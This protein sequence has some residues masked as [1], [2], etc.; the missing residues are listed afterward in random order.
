MSTLAAATGGA[1]VITTIARCLRLAF[2]SDIRAIRT[3]PGTSAPMSRLATRLTIAWLH[4]VQPIARVYGRLRGA[5]MS[6]EFQL[7]GEHRSA[8]APWHQVVL[9]LIAA[10]P[11]ALRFWSESWLSREALLTR[12]VERLRSTRV[13][14]ALDID[15][16]WHRSR[17][18]GLQLGQWGQLDVQ[19]LVEEHERGRVLVRIA[20][21]LRVR[22]FFGAVVACTGAL[23][24]SLAN[25]PTGGWVLAIPILVVAVLIVRAIWHA[26][27]T[28][29]L[30]D[31]VMTR[32]LADA[33]AMALDGQS[34]TPVTEIGRATGHAS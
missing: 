22:P 24:L 26:T 2:A 5:L 28:M 4:L 15:D 3:M 10:R 1:A 21:R 30:A 9:W 6:P 13:A 19:L 7:A 11:Q 8:P 12:I 16:G 23:L 25:A 20:R 34:V 29:G 18:V 32:V 17:D 31:E 27:A 14:T 33:G